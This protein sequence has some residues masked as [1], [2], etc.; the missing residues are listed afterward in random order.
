MKR[1]GG[2]LVH[3]HVDAEGPIEVVDTHGIRSL[4]FGTD[5]RQSAMALAQPDRLEMP[6]LRAMLAGLLFV[7]EPARILILGLGGGSLARF[8]LQQFPSVRIDAV[9]SRPAVVSIAREY[10]GL[11]DDQRLIIHNMTGEEYLA[12]SGPA[13][14]YDMILV[15]IFDAH[16]LSPAALQDDFLP[17]IS[18]RLHVGGVMGINLWTG[19]ATTWPMVIRS[20]RQQFP[21]G[22]YTLP[23]MGRGNLIGFG[24]G[25]RTTR[26]TRKHTPE[27]ARQLENRTGLE[28]TRLLQQLSLSGRG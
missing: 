5:A 26:L 6:Y 12:M 15:D 22:V 19:D 1:Y 25:T 14:V 27:R 7:S 20:L 3:C 11:P 8:L 28:L 13:G 16:G 9:E 23:V 2:S 10:F 24:V 21:A 17:A 4:H 18:P